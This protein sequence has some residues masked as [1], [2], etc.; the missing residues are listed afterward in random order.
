MTKNTIIDNTGH[1]ERLR[2]KFLD[3]KLTDYELLELLLCYAIPRCDV[4]VIARNLYKKYGNIQNVLSASIDDLIVNDG[5][6]INT[7][8]FFKIIH[9]LTLM[10]YKTVLDN[11]PIFEKYE[12]MVNYCKL[13][14]CDKDIEEFHVFYLDKQ[15]KLLLDEKHSSGTIDYSNV[16]IREIMKKA[17]NINAVNICVIHNHLTPHTNFS[18]QDIIITNELK[19]SLSVV[20]I[21]LLDHLIITP[22][23]VFSA[24][25]S[26]LIK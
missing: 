5:I 15:Y 3:G 9:K 12:D 17:L 4:R 10:H 18:E 13:L 22:T 11:T 1:R 19:K 16:Y 26:N 20:N 23:E 14:F 7:A 6:K 24:R 2:Q 21:E 8:V 25:K